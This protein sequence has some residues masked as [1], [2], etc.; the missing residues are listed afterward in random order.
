MIGCCNSASDAFSMSFG[1]GW[2]RDSIRPSPT[3][4]ARVPPAAENVACQI[5]STISGERV[6]DDRRITL[7]NSGA[8]RAVA[9]EAGESRWRA[10]GPKPKLEAAVRNKV[11]HRCVFG[12]A[13]GLFKWESY[14]AGAET[15]SG[16]SRRDMGQKHKR[17]GKTAFIPIKVMLSDPG[18]VE[19]VPLGMND[20]LGGESISLSRCGLI[21][22]AGEEAEASWISPRHANCTALAVLEWAKR[23]L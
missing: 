1:R 2:V 7:E 17:G 10:A 20:L 3:A 21:E 13:D 8:I 23:K 14:D 6:P 5:R 22:E 19:A 15:N 4:P 18:R 9:A 11:E 16:R 12:D